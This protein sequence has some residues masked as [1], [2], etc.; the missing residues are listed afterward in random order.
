MLHFIRERA[1][2]WVAWFIVGL[3]TIPFALWGVNSY[4]TGP[5]DIVVATVNGQPIQ[6]AEYQQAVKQYRDRMRTALKDKFDP[7]VFDSVEIK[8]NV[9]DSLIDKKLLVS[10]GQGSGQRVSDMTL[11]SIIHAT[12]AFQK[13]GTFDSERYALMLAR[14]GLTP[15]QYE[16]ELRI[17]SIVQEFTAN[18]Q[19]ATLAATYA[20]GNL[21]RLEKQTREIAYGV[22]PAL[23]V[24]DKVV[25]TDEQVQAYYA[26]NA[27]N[28]SAPERLD[29]NYIKLSL[30]SL[31][32]DISISEAEIKS[33]YFN[34][35]DQFVGPEQL[36]I[37]HILIEGDDSDATATIEN[38]QTRLQQGQTFSALATELSQDVGS[39]KQGGDLGFVQRGV[40][41][42]AFEDAAYALQS[43]GDISDIVTTE[44]GQH[45]IMLTA[46][47]K[48]EGKSFEEAKTDVESFL[49][50]QKAETLFYEKAELL[51]D[52]SYE[53][54]DNLEIAAEDL[55]LEIKTSVEFQRERNTVG[56]A[57]NPKVVAAAFSEDVLMND[58]NSAVIEL[59]KS[60]LLVLHK[61]KHTE[62]SQLGFD[63]VAPAIKEQLRFENAARI[64]KNQGEKLLG[65]LKSGEEPNNL[66][67]DSNWHSA[68]IYGR[69]DRVISQQILQYAFSTAKPE[70]S[71][72]PEFVG[73]TAQ[74]GNFVVLKVTDVTEGDL[75]TI[76]AEEY[77][78]LQSHLNRSYGDSELQAFI[79]EL[80]AGA[81]IKVFTNYL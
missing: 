10:V 62:A 49:I 38:I 31:M 5:S 80:K 44:F 59:T 39:A 72:Q 68:Q 66:F 64:A 26:I 48:P 3:I 55:N 30:D 79:N 15:E 12:A 18:V 57:T 20:S 61:N 73:F 81:D 76:S 11:L 69:S 45:L 54:P 63:S 33:Y 35:K 58:L 25:I 75:S 16:S 19:G 2:G 9:L 53:N 51:A 1:H 37:S 41:D 56:I 34:N 22:I 78:G 60:D 13:D 17:D 28:Y 32:S 36:K 50:R 43:V 7:T 65:K 70:T 21:L 6:Q 8:R 47:K 24:L 46:I 71:T 74:N 23:S 40:M 29:V 42:A 52:L 27:S 67:S 77:E 14:V 4:I